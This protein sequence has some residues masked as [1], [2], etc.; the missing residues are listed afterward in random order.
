MP[1]DVALGEEN[2]R[3]LL[4]WEEA[5]IYIQSAFGKMPKA[6]VKDSMVPSQ[7]Q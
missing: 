7:R 6:K 3:L 2:K 4:G 1:D 5:Q